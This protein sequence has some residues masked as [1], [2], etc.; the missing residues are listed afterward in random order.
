MNNS[1]F[2]FISYGI[3]TPI[4]YL[5]Y[6]ISAVLFTFLFG[7]PF[8]IGIYFINMA[9]NLIFKQMNI[10]GYYELSKTQS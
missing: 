3:F 4:I 8:A 10:W 6:F 2:E 1:F 5:I 9:T 7:L